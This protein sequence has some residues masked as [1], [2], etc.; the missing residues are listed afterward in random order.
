MFDDL[1][2]FVRVLFFALALLLAMLALPFVIC[3]VAD[4]WDAPEYPHTGFCPDCPA[5]DE[6]AAT[7]N[8]LPP[9]LD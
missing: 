2:E 5:W 3:H 1:S 6:D 7:D 9:C 8:S 4:T